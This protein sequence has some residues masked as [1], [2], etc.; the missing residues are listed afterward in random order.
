MGCSMKP[1]NFS[2][3]KRLKE[4]SGM[5]L[6]ESML[7][8]LILLV[9]LLVLAQVLTMSIVASKTYGRDAG[10]ATV[11]ARDKMEELS[12]LDF[13][14]AAL[15]AGGSIAPSSP[16]TG[17]VDRLNADGTINTNGAP[18]YTRQWQIID[19]SANL[20][21]IIVSVTSNRSFDHGTPPSTVMVTEKAP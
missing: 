2:M 21:R 15:N 4:A 14:N 5:T 18:D 20:K 10:K 1:E 8:I 19:D 11:S 12:G 13:T 16:V 6:I 17:Y 9:G 3:Y 7:S